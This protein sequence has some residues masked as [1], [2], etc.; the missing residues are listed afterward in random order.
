MKV[1]TWE[2][3][4]SDLPPAL[5]G[6]VIAHVS[7]LHNAAFGQAQQLL[8]SAIRA[9]QP[10][11]IAIT[12]DLIDRRRPGMQHALDFVRGGVQ[13]A[14]VYYA[15][16]NHEARSGEY[17]ALEQELLSLGVHVLRARA[18][19]LCAGAV[20]AG[21]DDPKFC[22]PFIKKEDALARVRAQLSSLKGAF[23]ILLSHHPEYLPAYDGANLV[24]SGHAHGG[25]VRL[26]LIGG[27]YAP[28]QGV[29]PRYTRGIYRRGDAAMVVSRGLG[30][31]RC[32][33]RIF[34]PPELVLVRLV[35]A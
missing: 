2:V 3:K 34:N 7:D 6:C 8:L 10:N 26:P 30:N 33:I 24:L 17:P 21:I 1:T 12:G 31:S 32:P 27:L 13:I 19:E 16:G 15:T 4:C 28:G 35:R 22:E 9:A 5:E 23:T 14:P 20:I 18:E 29:F 25:Q 11:F